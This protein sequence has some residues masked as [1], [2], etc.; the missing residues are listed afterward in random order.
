M[1]QVETWR[2]LLT[3]SIADG[4]QLLREV[5]DGPLRFAP[6]DQQYRFT[7][8]VTTGPLVAGLVG[9]PPTLSGVPRGI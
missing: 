5:L 8:D 3:T 9:L 2:T 4:R 7:G 1:A 6:E